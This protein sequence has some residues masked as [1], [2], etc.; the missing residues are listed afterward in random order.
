MAY[1]DAVFIVLVALIAS[2]VAE[3][4]LLRILRSPALAYQ[5]PCCC[6]VCEIFRTRVKAL[7]T[8]CV[9]FPVNVLRHN[10]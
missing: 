6:R 3:G 10:A 5:M 4:M 2:A 1:E 7:W 9:G 8:H